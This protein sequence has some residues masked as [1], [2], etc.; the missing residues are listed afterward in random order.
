MIP[1]F[2]NMLPLAVTTLTLPLSH[3]RGV[4]TVLPYFSYFARNL[5]EEIKT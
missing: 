5:S 3:L 2:G 4:V 1:Y